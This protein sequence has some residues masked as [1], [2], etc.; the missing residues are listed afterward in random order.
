MYESESHIILQV[1]TLSTL[2][3]TSAKAL[4]TANLLS[5]SIHSTLR[6]ERYRL[7][8]SSRV[9]IYGRLQDDKIPPACA[10]DQSTSIHAHPPVR[11][12]RIFL[13]D[14][15]LDSQDLLSLEPCP[16][17]HPDKCSSDDQDVRAQ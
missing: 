9:G 6:C 10:R 5:A 1:P 8:Q 4:A 16:P 13:H 3:T 15:A 12:R 2:P 17:D 7:R 14:H 11:I